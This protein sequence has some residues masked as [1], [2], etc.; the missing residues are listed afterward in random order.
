MLAS[1]KLFGPPSHARNKLVLSI[2]EGKELPCSITL[3][4]GND[5]MTLQ[6]SKSMINLTQRS[7]V[8]FDGTEDNIKNST[9]FFRFLRD[10]STSPHA[11]LRGHFE[12]EYFDK[13]YGCKVKPAKLRF[14]MADPG[15]RTEKR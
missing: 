13:Q 7:V 1:E 15:D 5:E 6:Y 12:V 14:L 8:N 2:Y 10:L 4:S 9:L 3:N 11:S